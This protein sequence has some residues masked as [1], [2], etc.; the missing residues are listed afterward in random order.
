MNKM[1]KIAASFKDSGLK[2]SWVA[3]TVAPTFRRAGFQYL[4]KYG[5]CELLGSHGEEDEKRLAVLMYQQ[6]KVLMGHDSECDGTHHKDTCTY[7]S[8]RTGKHEPWMNFPYK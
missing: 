4:A 8:P 5:D 3:K 2:L 6:G 1:D 7:L